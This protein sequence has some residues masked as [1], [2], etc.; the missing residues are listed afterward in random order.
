VSD[1]FSEQDDKTENACPLYRARQPYERNSRHAFYA[2]TS[3]IGKAASST[4]GC[5]L[6]LSSLD[7]GGHVGDAYG[8]AQNN[9]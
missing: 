1:E 7:D 8:E 9:P 2:F 5:S 3:A 6:R 4:E